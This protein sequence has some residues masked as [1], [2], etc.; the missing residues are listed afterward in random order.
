M[1]INVNPAQLY[2][3]ELNFLGNYI[4]NS[5]KYYW[6]N[7][8]EVN[9]EDGR[10]YKFTYNE[11]LLFDFLR[12][13]NPSQS[14]WLKEKY[15]NLDYEGQVAFW[16]ETI[17][18]GIYIHQ[19][20]FFGNITFEQLR[21]LYK[22]YPDCRPK[23]FIGIER[24]LIIGEMYFMKLKHEAISKFSA[25]SSSY[26]NIKNTPSKSTKF[27]ENQQLYSRTPVKVGEMELTNL[28]L[29]N[30][31]EEVARFMKAYSTSD[32]ERKNLITHLLKDDVFQLNKVE[33]QKDTSCTRQILD[34]YLAGIGLELE[35]N[36][37]EKPV[38]ENALELYD[39]ATIE[40]EE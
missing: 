27:K 35:R 4:R 36:C 8:K 12:D 39:P 19:P 28:L 14:E 37:S 22:T 21:E 3:Q 32:I 25:R 38:Q 18:K 9:E 1:N 30:N 16:E 20:P 15:D 23:K 34:A 33:V 24:P 40:P 11:Y 6:E 7:E 10:E 5:I 31:E 2:E 17:E 29:C 26:L 13:I